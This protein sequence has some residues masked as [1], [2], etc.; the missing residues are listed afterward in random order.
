MERVTTTAPVLDAS[1]LLALILKEPGAD[2]VIDA[3]KSGAKMSAVNLAEV[4]ARL[5]QFDWTEAEVALILDRLD[6]DVLPF[7]A[8]V[9]LLSGRYRQAT[10][11]LGLGLGDRACLATARFEERA[12]LTADRIW[13]RLNLEGV[14]VRCIR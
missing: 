11:P 12:V 9:A 10:R 2:I 4:A 5:H 3:L 13:G 1:A 8:D 6:I 7:G 14:E